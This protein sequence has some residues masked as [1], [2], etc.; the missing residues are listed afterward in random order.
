MP[1]LQIYAR[2]FEAMKPPAREKDQ[3]NGR[4]L[5]MIE[6]TPKNRDIGESRIR[7]SRR[8]SPLRQI[9]VERVPD[10]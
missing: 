7:I 6:G 8:N 3:I 5:D 1:D 2:D 4:V 10:A 9:I